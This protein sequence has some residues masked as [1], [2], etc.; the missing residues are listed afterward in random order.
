[1]VADVRQFDKNEFPTE[2]DR[3]EA[4]QAILLYSLLM[5]FDTSPPPGATVDERMIRK[6]EVHPSSSHHT[7]LS[8]DTVG[9]RPAH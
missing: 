2:L 8:T 7:F 3:L 9:D 4:L 1:M 5:Y 6:L